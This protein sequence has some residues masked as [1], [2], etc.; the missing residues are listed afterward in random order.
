MTSASYS[1]SKACLMDSAIRFACF[2]DQNRKSS[3]SRPITS[4][5]RDEIS[6][7]GRGVEG[8]CADNGTSEGSESRHK[9][10]MWMRYH[11]TLWKSSVAGGSTMTRYEE[12][13][14][15]NHFQTYRILRSVHPSSSHCI[16]RHDGSEPKDVRLSMRLEW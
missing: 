3:G 2:S 15:K 5:P 1:T 11:R 4:S 16:S 7:P 13:E 12:A 8:G 9:E 6:A 14:G 10:T